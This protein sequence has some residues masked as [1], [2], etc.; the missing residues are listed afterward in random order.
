MSS[1]EIKHDC[2]RSGE[3]YI[4]IVCKI[5]QITEETKD[6]KTFRIQKPDGTKPFSSEPG[7]LAMLSPIPAAESIFGI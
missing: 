1:I 4:P 6:V 7:Q 3:P 2:A 5:I